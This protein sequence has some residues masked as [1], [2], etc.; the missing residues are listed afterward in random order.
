MK[1]LKLFRFIFIIIIMLLF[2]I[3]VYSNLYKGNYDLSM[4][5]YPFIKNNT[6]QTFVSVGLEPTNLDMSGAVNIFIN[7]IMNEYYIKGQ[8]KGIPEREGLKSVFQNVIITDETFLKDNKIGIIIGGPCANKASAFL[9]NVTSTWP[10][11]AEK[12][13]PGIGYI[14]AFSTGNSLYLLVSGYYTEDTKKATLVM[15]D[16]LKYN[17]SGT[18]I[19]VTGDYSNLKVKKLR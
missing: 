2:G 15:L 1:K 3:I 10:D 17:L 7:L 4:Y 6:V 9:L 8:L 5:P 14:E 13:K 12:F 19:E 11:C 18:K 16:Y